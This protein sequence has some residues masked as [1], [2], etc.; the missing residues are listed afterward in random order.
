MLHLLTALGCALGVEIGVA[1]S[2]P[3]DNP[4]SGAELLGRPAPSWT[5][6]RWLR[7]KPLSLSRMRGKVVLVRWW[8]TGCH[9]CEATLPAIETLRRK[10]AGDGLVVIGVY[11]PK[12]P[13]RVSDRD[14]LEAADRLGFSGPL[15]VDTKWSTL[16]RYW[17]DGHPERNW[18]SVSFLIDRAGVVRWVHGGGEYHPSEESRHQ[19]CEVRFHEL[20]E[21]LE[22]ALAEKPAPL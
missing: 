12:P 8:T 13:R 1:A 6:D 11:H 10:H 16:E 2:L 14:V 5:F 22:Q 9:F 21:V 15:A 4:D 20:E 7:T 19:R 17:L 3:P 18:T